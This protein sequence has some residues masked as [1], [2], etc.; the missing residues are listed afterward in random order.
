MPAKIEDLELPQ[1]VN[2]V[3]ERFAEKAKNLSDDDKDTERAA[4]LL[5]SRGQK[6]S[7]TADVLCSLVGSAPGIYSVFLSF[8][9]SVRERYGNSWVNVVALALINNYSDVLTKDVI[10]DII[11]LLGGAVV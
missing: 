3:I 6:T 4:I 8:I 10:E 5:Y 7:E 2:E 11:K 9:D 1:L